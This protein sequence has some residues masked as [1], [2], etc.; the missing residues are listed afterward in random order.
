[1]GVE[2]IRV[3]GEIDNTS[4]RQYR[5]HN[6]KPAYHAA[7]DVCFFLRVTVVGDIAHGVLVG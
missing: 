6:E 5:Q 1:M 4:E 7:M 3:G 2:E